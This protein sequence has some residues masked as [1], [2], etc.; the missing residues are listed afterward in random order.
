MQESGHDL[1]IFVLI[2]CVVWIMP[3]LRV[4]DRIGIGNAYSYGG[5]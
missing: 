1:A 3:S 4:G 5:K 2:E